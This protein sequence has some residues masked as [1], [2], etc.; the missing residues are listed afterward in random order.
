[1]EY[2]LQTQKMIREERRRAMG[3]KKGK[4]G[5]KGIGAQRL[6]IKYL[7]SCME[8]YIHLQPFPANSYAWTIFSTSCSLVTWKILNVNLANKGRKASRAREKKK[9]NKTREE[10][11][12]VFSNFFRLPQTV[13]HTQELSVFKSL[14]QERMGRNKRG[15]ET[16][17]NLWV[18][19]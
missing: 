4:E 5:G 7:C 18:L 16:E 13:L 1:M 8:Y 3:K 10:I 2:L 19:R 6:P 15:Y 12:W 14:L 9:K 11:I 17:Q